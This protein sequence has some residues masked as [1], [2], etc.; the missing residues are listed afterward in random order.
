MTEP[1]I[2]S[3]RES[4]QLNDK[5]IRLIGIPF[6]GLVIPH[7]TGLVENISTTDYRFWISHLYF[8]VLAGLICQGNRYLLF[9]TRRRF[10]WFD[11]PIEKLVL[12]VVNNI[13]YTAPHQMY[14]H[15]LK[16]WEEAINKY[17][18]KENQP[19]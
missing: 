5:L 1:E 6:F 13:F 17:L 3:E 4:I 19:E 18:R 9:R 16:D 7:V 11:R 8:I 2:T 14:L 10:T 12:L 15:E